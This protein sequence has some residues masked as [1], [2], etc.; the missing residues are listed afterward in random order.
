MAL[1]GCLT[2][3]AHADE[4]GISFWLPGQFGSLAAAPAV[5]GWSGAAIYYHTTVSAF[6]AVAAARDSNRQVLA[7]S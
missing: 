4:S 3:T 6:G 1:L 5:P 7:D 2:E